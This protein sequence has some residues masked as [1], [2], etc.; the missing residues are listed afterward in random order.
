MCVLSLC[1]CFGNLFSGLSAGTSIEIMCM[2]SLSLSGP[3]GSFVLSFLDQH[4]IL[5][6]CWCD[7]LWLNLHRVCNWK[8]C[9]LWVRAI[10][11]LPLPHSRSVLHLSSLLFSLNQIVFSLF[12]NTVMM[13][14]LPV[15]IFPWTSLVECS[16]SVGIS[17]FVFVRL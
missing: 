16:S 15:G 8:F 1:R 13:F 9:T 4:C 11:F 17:V 10:C 6:L 5:S 2:W 7:L 14:R 3:P 12:L